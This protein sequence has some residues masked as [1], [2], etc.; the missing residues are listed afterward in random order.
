MEQVKILIGIPS[1][2]VQDFQSYM[3]KNGVDF[4]QN[5]NRC[6]SPKLNIELQKLV[7]LASQVDSVTVGGAVFVSLWK[8]L[9]LISVYIKE[10]SKPIQI[11]IGKSK[12][13]IPGNTSKEQVDE[14]VEKFFTKIEKDIKDKNERVKK[15]G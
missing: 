4:S 3:K 8:I 13:S 7:Q 9:N 10:K 11:M 14:V 5:E 2:S 12:L 1:E 15:Q 6:S